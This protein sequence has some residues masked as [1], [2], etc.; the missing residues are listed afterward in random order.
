[1]SGVRD[2]AASRREAV[3]L[4]A[5]LGRGR[6]YVGKLLF[7]RAGQALSLQYHEVKD[8]AWLV[9]E[10]RASLELGEVGGE[11]ETVE[12]AR[13]RRVPLPAGH[14]APRDGD[15]GLAD[16]RGLDPAPRRR[17]AARGPVRARG[18]ERGIV[19]AWCPTKSDT[20]RLT[21]GDSGSWQRVI[22]TAAAGAFR[23]LPRRSR[24][25]SRGIRLLPN[26]AWRTA[27][28]RTSSRPPTTCRRVTEIVRSSTRSTPAR[29]RSLST[30]S[31]C[32]NST[33]IS[34]GLPGFQGATAFRS[35]SAC[36]APASISSR[37]RTGGIWRADVAPRPFFT[38]TVV[39]PSPT[40]A[41]PLGARD[42]VARHE[43]HRAAPRP[44]E[45]R[46]DAR[47]RRRR[48]VEAEVEVVTARRRC[49]S[50]RRGRRRPSRA[51]RRGVPR[52][53]PPR[54]TRCTPSSP[55]GRRTRS[56]GGGDRERAS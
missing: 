32:L 13:G 38:A 29:K 21:P 22:A 56:P 26:P 27:R 6:G 16:R 54:G 20:F 24:G 55:P 9:Q 31:V 34:H 39:S 2:D 5:R 45:G 36:F 23:D 1:M 46:V 49:G 25:S 4:G 50:S 43:Q 52:R 44:A 33:M 47:S 10:G 3:G 41:R 51:S 7:V 37:A 48:P 53:S 40:S 17:R 12:I 18:D 35:E 30:A 42:V 8:E 15:R 19:R 28:S 11:L 14:R